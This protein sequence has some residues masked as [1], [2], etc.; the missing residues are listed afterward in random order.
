MKPA[1]AQPTTR[2]ETAKEL[3]FLRSFELGDFFQT[4]AVAAPF[5]WSIQPDFDQTIDQPFAEHI[6]GK[7]EHVEVVVTAAHFGSEIVVAR[8]GTDTW[9]FVGGNA[10]ADTTTA[11]KNPAIDFARAE[12]APDLGSHIRVIA[13]IVA[14]RA[15]VG[16]FVTKLGYH[17]DEL[18]FDS[19]STMIAANRYFH[20]QLQVL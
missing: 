17:F 12:F 20:L 15:D 16:H 18:S 19:K 10:H 14:K 3:R 11:E 9:N 7:T 13:T 6:R 5:E 2:Q 1:K 4:A 8:G